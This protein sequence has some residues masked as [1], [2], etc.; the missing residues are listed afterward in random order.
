MNIKHEGLRLIAYVLN[1]L[2]WIVGTI[3]FISAIF[4][5]IN[6]TAVFPK[7]YLLML[8]LLTTAIMTCLLLALSKLIY[9][10]IDIEDG[11][12]ELTGRSKRDTKV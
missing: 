5:G 6:A 2:A 7:I 1:I 12:S 3:G 4:L 8:G 10:F 11:L 9:L